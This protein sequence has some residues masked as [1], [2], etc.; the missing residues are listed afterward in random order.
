MDYSVFMT[1]TLAGLGFDLH[2]QFCC[3]D[4]GYDPVKGWPLKLPDLEFGRHTLLMLHFQDF[5]T[6]NDH[7][8]IELQ[9]VQDHYGDRAGQVLIVHW[10][11]RLS[12]HYQGPL[13]LIEFNSHEYNILC[14][15]QGLRRTWSHVGTGPRQ[16]WF[17]SLNGRQC[18]HRVKTVQELEGLEG[19]VSYGDHVPLARWPYS[20]YA[21]VENE[22][23]FLRL[24]NVYDQC[25]INVITETQYDRAPGII[26]EKTFLALLSRQ[27]PL[28]IGYPG[29][30]SDCVSL[31]F[32][33]FQ[34]LVDTSY[35][36]LPN[37]VRVQ[38]AV[39]RNRKLL[40]GQF[41]PEPLRERLDR[42]HDWLLNRYTHLL[43]QRF[44]FDAK[45]LAQKLLA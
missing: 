25:W 42:Q 23:N 22:D 5:V 6:A 32:D 39:S 36:N 11:H 43:R 31:G 30:V 29:I 24:L 13:N 35:D 26:T 44:E 8:I 45:T 27:I 37:S 34:D 9:R 10:P 7:G 3:F 38:Q 18:S 28:V 40:Q 15:L 41:D 4:V 19:I 20:S 12:N 1:Q 21:G 2:T 16:Y 17:Q 33:M 14:N